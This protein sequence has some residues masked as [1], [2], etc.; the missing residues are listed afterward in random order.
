MKLPIGFDFKYKCKRSRSLHLSQALPGMTMWEEQH[1]PAD[2]TV[3][4]VYHTDNG[5][6]RLW[7]SGH[8]SEAEGTEADSYD[9]HGNPIYRLPTGNE[10]IPVYD[11]VSDEST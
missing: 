10:F 11:E 9:E 8:E 3:W 1:H 2:H 7:L 4:T 5:W 6:S